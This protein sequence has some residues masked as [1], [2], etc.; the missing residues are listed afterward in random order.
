[1]NDS[2]QD[3]ATRGAHPAIAAQV[4]DE[5]SAWD[6]LGTVDCGR[7]IFRL[8]SC[9]E[10]TAVLHLVDDQ[11]VIIRARLTP[12]DAVDARSTNGALVAY[13]AERADADTHTS[14]SV[15]VFGRAH[16]LT[17]PGRVDRYKRRLRPWVD[18]ADTILAIEPDIVTAIRVACAGE[19][20]GCLDA[21]ARDIVSGQFRCLLGL[22][23]HD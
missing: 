15:L 17:D 21:T 8:M 20:C 11:R 19:Q 12:T 18:Y 9:P 16:A 22:D 4:L 23:N 10:S 13:E 5:A 6:L 3:A 1:M 14:W 2:I 7:V